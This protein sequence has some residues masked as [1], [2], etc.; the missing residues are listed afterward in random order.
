M[1][2]CVLVVDD[3]KENSILVDSIHLMELE[4]LDVTTV[5][6]AELC[7]EVA[8][9]I[10]PDVIVIDTMDESR[11]YK[12]VCDKLR[13]NPFVDMVPMVVLSPIGAEHEGN[14]WITNPVNADSITDAVHSALS[15]IEGNRVLH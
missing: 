2:Y 10:H 4:D 7:G 8:S 9:I 13:A 1:S 15:Y 12:S 3:H 5:A 11:G 14:T 6:G